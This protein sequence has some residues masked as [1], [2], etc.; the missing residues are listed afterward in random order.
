[1][2]PFKVAALHTYNCTQAN[3]AGS[4]WRASAPCS[5]RLLTCFQ[6]KDNQTCGAS[7]MPNRLVIFG[8]LGDGAVALNAVSE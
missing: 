5:G 7:D 8:L 1:M 3:R 4:L 2:P 6:Q